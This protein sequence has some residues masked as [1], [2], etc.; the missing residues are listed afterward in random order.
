MSAELFMNHSI[1]MSKREAE[2]IDNLVFMQA[3]T[4]RVPEFCIHPCYW[5]TE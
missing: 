2:K 4:P 3:S 1:V 5:L